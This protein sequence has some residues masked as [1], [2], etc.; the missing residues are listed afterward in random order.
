[1]HRDPKL[2]SPE[3]VSE[4]RRLESL[5]TTAE[6]VDELLAEIAELPR[7]RARFRDEYVIVAPDG[8]I[9]WANHESL[10]WALGESIRQVLRRRRALR[11]NER[12][13][14]A[15]E[16]IATDRAVGKG[17]EPYVMLLAQYGGETRAPLL[18]Q[19][20]DDPEVVGHALYGLRL[21]GAQGAER[22]ARSLLAHPRAWI[23]KEARKYLEK[24]DA[25]A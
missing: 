15:I 20:L 24:V 25:A 4:H 2:P 6:S 7:R 1:M 3:Y 21:H 12:L 9:T 16:T 5:G 13:W 11:K 19:L 10:A 14:T 23:R 17:R 22:Q 8:P 18:I